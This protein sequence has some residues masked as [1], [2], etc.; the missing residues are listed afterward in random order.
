MK[1]PLK[2]ESLSKAIDVINTGAKQ[3]KP[4]IFKK[5]PFVVGDVENEESEDTDADSALFVLSVSLIQ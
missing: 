4:K 1:H 5:K 2:K 3:L